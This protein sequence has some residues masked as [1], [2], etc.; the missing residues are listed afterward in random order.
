MRVCKHGCD[1][2]QI[3]TGYVWSDAHFDWLVGNGNMY[4]ENLFQS[5]SKKT[6]FSFICQIIFEK[7]F[8]K[9]I[10]DFFRVY[11]ASSKH[12]GELGELET[13]MQT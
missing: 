10:G 13:V 2:T 4:Q 9:A 12:E 11:I 7:Y 5:R 6:E 8:T 3:F 1:I